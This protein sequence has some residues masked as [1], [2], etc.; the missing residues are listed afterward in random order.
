MMV[1]YPMPMAI[2]YHHSLYCQ[3]VRVV[4]CTGNWPPLQ[5]GAECG[6][7][8][9]NSSSVKTGEL[10][11]TSYRGQQGAVHPLAHPC[12]G[13]GDHPGDRGCEGCWS[14]DT[15]TAA[16][17]IFDSSSQSCGRRSSGN[18]RPGSA[19]CTVPTPWVLSGGCA[20]RE[21]SVRGWGAVMPA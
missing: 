15:P 18:T 20:D 17:F 1:F 12:L 13:S 3:A 11:V 6:L 21:R 4:L 2:S 16:I 10:G 9:I 14:R 19:A 8:Q 5:A 7:G